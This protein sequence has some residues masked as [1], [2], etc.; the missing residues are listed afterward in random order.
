M[1]TPLRQA[2]PDDAPAISKLVQA[3]FMERVAPDW[4][5]SA[6]QDFLSGTAAEELAARIAE[7]TLVAVYEDEGQI[8]GVISLPR[9]TLVQLFFV[10]PGHLRRGVGRVLQHAV[11]GAKL[12]PDPSIE[13]A[14]WNLNLPVQQRGIVTIA[15]TPAP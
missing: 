11:G 7:A 9:P 2:S 3:G 6:R 14:A 13:A 4:E 10:A 1:N 12:S 8:L 5:A 15:G